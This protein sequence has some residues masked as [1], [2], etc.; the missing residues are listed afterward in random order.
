MFC[1]EG[2]LL[3]ERRK[4]APKTVWHGPMPVQEEK[5]RF[6]REKD[7]ERGKFTAP[8][9]SEEVKGVKLPARPAVTPPWQPPPF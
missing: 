4:E 9:L 2:R 5:R 6:M 1:R 7:R 3:F 8:L